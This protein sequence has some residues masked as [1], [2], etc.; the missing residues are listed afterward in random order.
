ML[1]ILQKICI[2]T[3]LT[4]IMATVALGAPPEIE[5]VFVK[6]G[7]FMMGDGFGDGSVDEK[8]VHE[9][10]I[11][12]Y[13]IGKYEVTQAQWQA[14]MGKNPAEFDSCGPDCPVENVTWIDVQEFIARLNKATGKNYRLPYET[15]WEYAARSGGKK[16]KWAGT[17]DADKLDDYAWLGDNSGEQ[18][19]RVGSKKPNG[20][21]LHDMTGN[22]WEWVEDCYD[23]TYYR[24]SSGKNPRG[25]QSGP[26]RVVRGG[27]WYDMAGD[28]RASARSDYST[29]FRNSALGFRLAAP[30]D[31]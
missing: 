20:L 25:P 9:A 18:P 30:S 29:L 10:C 23:A 28:A 1:C 21:G 5:M 7:C 17:S 6:G 8:P 26:L 24:K 15:E 13:L 22:V 16:E 11:D 4:F 12:D 27:S 14:I 2:F 3:L 31:R 19:H